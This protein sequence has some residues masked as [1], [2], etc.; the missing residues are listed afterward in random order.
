MIHVVKIAFPW[1]GRWNGYFLAEIRGQEAIPINGLIP[2]WTGRIPAEVFLSFRLA[3]R[4]LAGRDTHICEFFIRLQ[5]NYIWV[6]LLTD[7][8]FP[9]RSTHFIFHVKEMLFLRHGSPLEKLSRLLCTN[10]RFQSALHLKLDLQSCYWMYQKQCI[11][12]FRLH[13]QVLS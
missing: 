10:A 12:L 4:K 5:K 7:H 8:G 1:R 3:P 9:P 2:F 13:V 11:N 6:V